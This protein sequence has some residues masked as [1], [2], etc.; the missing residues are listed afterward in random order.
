MLHT[1]SDK[2]GCNSDH[3]RLSTYAVT[4]FD[5][6]KTL[7]LRNAFA[8]DLRTR[9][10][11]LRGVIRRAIVDEDVFGLQDITIQVEMQTPGRRAFDFPRTGQKVTAFMEWLRIQE[12]LGILEIMPGVQ[13][14]Q[15]VENAWTNKYIESSYQRGIQRARREMIA[16]G[17]D[18]PSIEATGGIGFAVNQPV[19]ADRLGL[20]FTRTFNDLKGITDAMDSQIS[21]VLAQA[22]AEGQGPRVM[23]NRLTKTISG[24]VG[25]LGLTDTLGRFI[26]AQ[27]RAEI[28]ARTETIRSHHLAMIQEYK[29]WGVEGVIVKAEFTTAGDGRVCPDCAALEGRIFSLERI[30][31][32]IPLHPQ[33]RCIAIPVEVGAGN[34]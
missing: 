31:F 26:P 5:P 21:R 3:S 11:K 9:F 33:C 14:G 30:E 6:T 12:E 18:I 28:L 32:L 7:T 1:H 22:L 19:H 20:M 23:A 4:Q 25:D 29:N 15:A 2:C 8:R 17:H 10:T 27:R 13:L 34:A 24:P 16:A